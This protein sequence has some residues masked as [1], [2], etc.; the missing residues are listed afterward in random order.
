MSSAK[1]M[2]SQGKVNLSED[3]ICEL[4][5]MVPV[6][7][8]DSDIEDDLDESVNVDRRAFDA[9]H[10]DLGPNFLVLNEEEEDTVDEPHINDTVPV[11]ASPHMTYQPKSSKCRKSSRRQI[12]KFR[13][14][15]DEFIHRVDKHED[16]FTVHLENG[17]PLDYF[18]TFFSDNI[19]DLIVQNT[20]LYSV[21]KT[22]RS[23]VKNAKEISDFIA[24][25]ILMGNICLPAYTDYW[26][27]EMRID[28]IANIMPLKKYQSLRRYLH[29]TDNSQMNDDRYF[30]VRPLLES[31][32]KS[33]LSIE[34]EKM[35]SVDEMMI[36]YKG[37][38]AGSRRQYVKSKPKKW[39]FKM[40]V[41]SGVS[42]IVYDFLLYGGEAT[43]CNIQFS[44]EEEC[45]G[46]EVK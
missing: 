16:N 45:L 39:G 9:G 15:E 11:P 42:G 23:I 25:E 30:K 32:R 28:H 33:C 41:R 27:Q 14:L 7:G 6:S 3:E 24:I 38:R 2:C 26:S 1:V 37:T 18:E 8:A 5:Y 13:W 31:V 20:N 36:P 19:V 35:N 43:F 4:L 12:K 21:Q 22:G 34:Q 29:F 46:W 17:S 10:V 40:F 44:E